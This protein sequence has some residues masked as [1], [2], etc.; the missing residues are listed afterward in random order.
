MAECVAGG[1]VVT[2]ESKEG[3]ARLWRD[4]AK[5]RLW[6]AR[7]G[8]RVLRG[9]HDVT[10]MTKATAASRVFPADALELTK[11]DKEAAGAPFRVACEGVCDVMQHTLCREAARG[12]HPEQGVHMIECL[13]VVAGDVSL[14]LDSE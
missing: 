1:G 11:E 14:E 3:E 13:R 7:L 10:H 2:K 6:I 12:R 8:S 4:A 9:Q 5:L